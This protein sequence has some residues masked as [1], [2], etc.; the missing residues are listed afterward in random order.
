MR[1]SYFLLLLNTYLVSATTYRPAPKKPA[2]IINS[3]SMVYD[4]LTSLCLVLGIGF[5]LMSLQKYM[6]YRQNPLANPFNRV[7]S[8]LI[9]GAVLIGM[10]YM[11]LQS[12]G[13]SS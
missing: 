7:M 4:F 5:V 8:L 6:E 11:P 1:L 13:A 10:Y 12:I 2:P 9:T 3:V